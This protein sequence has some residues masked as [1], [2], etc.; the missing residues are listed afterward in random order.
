[1]KIYLPLQR[2]TLQLI[3]FYYPIE[4]PGPLRTEIKSTILATLIPVLQS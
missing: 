2:N 4:I 1:M 3:K